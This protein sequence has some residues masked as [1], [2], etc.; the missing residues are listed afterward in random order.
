MQ[1]SLPEGPSMMQ[2]LS[3]ESEL[4]FPTSH[5]VMPLSDLIFCHVA[6]QT[7]LVFL[8]KPPF[9]LPGSTALHPGSYQNV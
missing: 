6:S 3:P 8:P 7:L 1:S 4:T 2:A 9:L 5:L